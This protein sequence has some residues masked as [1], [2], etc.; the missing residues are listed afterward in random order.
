MDNPARTLYT[1]PITVNEDTVIVAYAVLDGYEDSN[2]NLFI[3]TVKKPILL[4][5]NCD[6]VVSILDA[7]EIQKYLV[8]MVEFNGT[9]KSVADANGD[10]VVSILDATEIQKYLV[11]LSSILSN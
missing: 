4:D 10:G 7:T 3:Y 1:G 6:G 2:T 8:S 11:G 9:Q 5:V